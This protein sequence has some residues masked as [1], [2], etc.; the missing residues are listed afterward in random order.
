MKRV[1]IGA[2]AALGLSL[3]PAVYAHA[4]DKINLED[5]TINIYQDDRPVYL[6]DDDRRVIVRETRSPVFVEKRHVIHEYE[7]PVVIRHNR[8]YVYEYDD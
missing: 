3:W 1:L 8:T 6:N 2:M 5:A 4:R 7:D